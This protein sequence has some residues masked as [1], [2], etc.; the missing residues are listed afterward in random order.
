MFTLRR[1]ISEAAPLCVLRGTDAR[2]AARTA[3]ELDMEHKREMTEAE[4]LREVRLPAIG[5]PRSAA[6]QW[7]DHFARH[8]QSG[9]TKSLEPAQ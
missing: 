6:M 1:R 8:F 9:L 3:S 5:L 7:A 4:K 2:P